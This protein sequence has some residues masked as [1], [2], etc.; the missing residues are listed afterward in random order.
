M[1]II[2]QLYCPVMLKACDF[3]RYINKQQYNKEKISPGLKSGGFQFSWVFHE[4]FHRRICVDFPS[5]YLRA[6]IE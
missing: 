6:H 2:K 1:L 5:S 3:T 4:H